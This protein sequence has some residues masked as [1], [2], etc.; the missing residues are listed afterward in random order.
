[1]LDEQGLIL[2]FQPYTVAGGMDGP[3]IVRISWNDLRGIIEPTHPLGAILSET[4]SSKCFVSS[5]D[6][7]SF[8]ECKVSDR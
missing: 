3:P 7:D 6:K 1:M 8:I 5:W 2:V 4:I